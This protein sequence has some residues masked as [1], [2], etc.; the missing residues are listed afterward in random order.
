MQ[1]EVFTLLRA[2]SGS[3]DAP[4][5]AQKT[6]LKQIED[7]RKELQQKMDAWY[8]ENWSAYLSA[9]KDVSFAPIGTN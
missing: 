7:R 5:Q 6:S 8:A 2:V 9:V 1:T 4:V 3:Y